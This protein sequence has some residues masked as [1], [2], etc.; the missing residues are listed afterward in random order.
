M[1]TTAYT[2]AL[3]AAAA[4]S[5]LAT[6][7][8][9]RRGV[10]TLVLVAVLASVCLLT[11]GWYDWRAQASIETDIKTYVII[12]TL[13]IAVTAVAIATLRHRQ[14]R[15]MAQWAIGV[16]AFCA[17]SVVGLFLSLLFNWITI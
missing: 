17:S 10:R 2:V 5:S 6:V 1:S 8:A 3:I 7:V 4:A 12:G 11:L 15:T 14:A 13:P 9:A 16:V